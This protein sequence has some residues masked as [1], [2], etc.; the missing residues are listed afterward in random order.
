[1][2]TPVSGF[3]VMICKLL[4]RHIKYEK[5]QFQTYEKVQE[6]ESP[7]TY[8]RIQTYE[9]AHTYEA[10]P[11]TAHD[12]EMQHLALVW[13]IESRQS[14]NKK[15]HVHDSMLDSWKSKTDYVT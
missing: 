4:L 6:Y 7:Q 8:E 10:L 5:A 14:G 1:M 3:D 13:G 15:N 11:Q 9:K 12:L 2:E